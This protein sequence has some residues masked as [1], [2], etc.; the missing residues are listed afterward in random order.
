VRTTSGQHGPYSLGYTHATMEPT[1]GIAK[2]QDGANPIKRLLSGDWGLQFAPM[3]AELV[4]IAD[5]LRC[6]EYVLGSC[7][8]R[9][10]LI[11]A[12]GSYFFQ[13]VQIHSPASCRSSQKIDS[14]IWVT[15]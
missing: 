13:V 5:Q 12:R 6:G 11:K 3:N 8:H 7:T 14:P 4:V 1:E 15:E 2:S 10:N 9:R